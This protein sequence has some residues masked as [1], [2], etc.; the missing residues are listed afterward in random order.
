MAYPTSWSTPTPTRPP[1]RNRGLWWVLGLGVL[2]ALCAGCSAFFTGMVL[3]P[4]S[5][6]APATV[7]PVTARPSPIHAATPTPTSSS[8]P[9]SEAGIPFRAVVQ[10]VALDEQGEPLWTGSGSII[11]PDGLLLTN[12]HV[13]LPEP[14]EG[15]SRVTLLVLST[16]K[17]DQPP[18][19]RFYA[20][21]VQADQRLDLAVLRITRD[22]DGR[23]IDPDTLNLPFLPLG[24][25]EDLRLGDEL[26][27]LGYPGIGGDTITLTKGEVAGFVEDPPYGPRAFI[28]TTA[29]LAGGNSG[30]AAINARGELVAVPTLVGTGSEEIV[31]CRVL[32]DTNH[33]GVV[34]DRDSC[35]PIGGFLN[36][37]RPV[38]LALPL[39]EAARHGEVAISTPPPTPQRPQDDLEE[40]WRHPGPLLDAESFDAPVSGW[41]TT[42]IDPD[43]RIRYADGVMYVELLQDDYVQ[44]LTSPVDEADVVITARV[45]VTQPVGDGEYGLTCRYQDMDNFYAATVTEWGDFA[46]WKLVEG[47]FVELHPLTALPDEAAFEP[48]QWTELGLVCL[49]SRMGLWVNQVPVAMVEDPAASVGTGAGLVVSTFWEPDFEVAFDEMA[50]HAAQR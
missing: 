38:D 6:A 44:F 43:L 2:L 34:D 17:E 37:L 15:P 8:T 30:G 21:V 3:I 13:A 24:R 25:T 4:D 18:Q 19:P 14:D 40:V 26:I 36:A 31:D 16:E 10:I 7:I 46:L 9:P 32:V 23:R 11:G 29:T 20:E 22:A 42:N 41:T 48:T 47:E 27:I 49:G 39:V 1:R 5:T 12:A 28:K 33:D 45:R 50:I 35:V